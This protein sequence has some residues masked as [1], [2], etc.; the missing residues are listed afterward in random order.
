VKVEMTG[1]MPNPANVTS[2]VRTAARCSSPGPYSSSNH[3]APTPSTIGAQLIGALLAWMLIRW[4]FAEGAVGRV[5][6]EEFD[7]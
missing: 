5:V 3:A 2:V 1:P 6:G 4:I 7:R